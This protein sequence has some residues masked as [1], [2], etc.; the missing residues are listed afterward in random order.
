MNVTPSFVPNL[1]SPTAVDPR[2]RPFYDPAIATQA[3]RGL[4]AT[5]R[6]PWANAP[7]AQGASLLGRVI[8]LIGMEL[9]CPSPESDTNSECLAT[10]PAGIDWTGTRTHKSFSGAAPAGAAVSAEKH[11]PG[12]LTLNRCLVQSPVL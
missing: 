4:E 8:R 12:T 1:E 6:D 3:L 9:G 2:L 10:Q 5:P 11:A 7:L